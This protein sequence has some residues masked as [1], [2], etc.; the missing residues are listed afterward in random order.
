MHTRPVLIALLLA[1]CTTL[2]YQPQSISESEAYAVIS[3]V[4]AQQPGSLYLDSSYLG[5]RDESDSA[6]GKPQ[7]IRARIYF[8]ALEDIE[9]HRSMRGYRV[10]LS[11][12]D[13]KTLGEFLIADR[14]QAERFVDAL[15]RYRANAPEF[16]GLK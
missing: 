11:G 2:D 9:L 4:T 3:A 13:N 10:R 15:A 14:R 5:F 8:N 16:S 12:A 1:G 7:D 6:T